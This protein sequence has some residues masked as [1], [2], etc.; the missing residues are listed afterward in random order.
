VAELCMN[1][2][3]TEDIIYWPEVGVAEVPTEE[4][5][6]EMGEDLSC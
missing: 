3:L 2:D 6:E 5:K 1:E 4:V